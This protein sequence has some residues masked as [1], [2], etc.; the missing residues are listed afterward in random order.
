MKIVQV[1]SG[2]VKI[3]PSKGGAVEEHILKLSTEL[4]RYCSVSIVDRFYENEKNVYN[5]NRIKIKRIKA[6][7][8][9]AH[10]RINH[11][12]N[13]IIFAKRL[14]DNLE[15]FK[16]ADIIHAHNLYTGYYALK[17]AKKVGAKFIYT[18]HNGMW[19]TN[20]VNLYEK[21]IVRKLESKIMKEADVSIAVSENLRQNIIQK[22]KAPEN[23]IITIYNGVDTDF[24]NPNVG[25][26]DIVQKYDLE[27]Y[28]TVVFVGRIT[29]A[30]GVEYLIKALNVLRDY[31]IKALLVGPFKYMF[32]ESNGKSKYAESLLSL[33][34]KCDL[35][36]RVIFTD[37]VPKSELPKYYVAGDVFVLPSIYE[38]MGMVLVEAMACGKPLIGSRVGGIPE[39]IR[40]WENGLL[41]KPKDHRDLAEKILTLMND[42]IL[43][44]KMGRNGRRIAENGYS[45]GKIAERLF[46][47]VYCETLK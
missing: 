1:S 32:Q 25:C 6:R 24:F 43:R 2:V 41:F 33:V 12:L 34:E 47:D 5:L 21:V 15:I 37:A 35:E 4:S 46:K 31:K 23:S 9:S 27:D 42:E 28:F 17:I 10:P 14:C 22:G 36:G 7:M 19:C 30:K 16:D 11:I 29:P 3:P 44:A 26:N 40:E 39:I 18:C 45:W 13:E 8:I 20:D 38:A